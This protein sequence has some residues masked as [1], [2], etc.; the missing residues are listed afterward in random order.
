VN[1]VGNHFNERGHG[2]K[3]MQVSVL[4]KVRPTSRHFLETREELWIKRLE[5][6]APKGLNKNEGVS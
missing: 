2:Q 5:T 1:S 3:D 6:M 4:E